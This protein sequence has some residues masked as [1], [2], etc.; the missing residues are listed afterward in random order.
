MKISRL[1]TISLR[2][3]ERLAKINNKSALVNKALEKYFNE[4]EQF[5]MADVE[6]AMLLNVLLTRSD[7]SVA[8]KKIIEVELWE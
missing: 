6:T 5:S 3:V 7:I 8:L 4:K 1:Y 2:N